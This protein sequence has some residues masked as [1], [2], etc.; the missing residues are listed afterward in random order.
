MKSSNNLSQIG[1]HIITNLNT[2]CTM[3][4]A[5]NDS[6]RQ[7]AYISITTSGTCIRE[8]GLFGNI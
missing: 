7:D 8:D 3:P 1:D 5:V 2:L 6:H 4:N